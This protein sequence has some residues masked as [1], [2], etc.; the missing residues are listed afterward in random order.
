MWP[1]CFYFK[2]GHDLDS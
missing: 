1:S 2:Y